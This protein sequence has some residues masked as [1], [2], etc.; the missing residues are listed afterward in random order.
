MMNKIYAYNLAADM[1]NVTI[2]RHFP[3]H[4]SDHTPIINPN[5]SNSKLKINK[6]IFSIL[7]SN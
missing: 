3:P 1:F 4:Y 2:Y 6:L 5:I 7:L